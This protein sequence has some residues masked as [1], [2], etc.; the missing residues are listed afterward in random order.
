MHPAP[1]PD[2]D[3]IPPFLRFAPVPVR[4]RRDGWTPELQF[5]FLL[6]LA[7]GAGADEAAR[8]LGRRRQSV[9]ALRR[10]AGAESFAAAWDA[11]VDFAR[12]ARGA[13][14]AMPLGS[15]R[16]AI[17]TLL[18][19]RFY[20]G[21]LIGFVQ[22]EDVSSAMARL[23]RLDRLAERIEAR[24]ESDALRAMSERLGPLLDGR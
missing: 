11:A 18:V 2:P 10:R 5:R 22:R 4:S 7:R 6:A 12:A 19:P 16:S 24:G 14:A 23:R 21:R 9:Y 3:N 13:V 8:T 20:R 1:R 17:E 15:G